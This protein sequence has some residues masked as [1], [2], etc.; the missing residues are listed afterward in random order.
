MDIKNISRDLLSPAITGVKKGKEVSVHSG[1]DRDAQNGQGDL[2]RGQKQEEPMSEEAFN[3]ALEQLGDLK[4]IKEHG[5]K[6]SFKMEGL[7]RIIFLQEPSGKTLRR[8]TEAELREL[9]KV[10]KGQKGQLLRKTA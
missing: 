3:E 1:V 10:E 6:I 5:L 8:L 2:G 7:Y 9:L 4:I